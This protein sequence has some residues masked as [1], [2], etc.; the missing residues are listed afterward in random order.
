MTI[1]LVFKTYLELA[2]NAIECGNNRLAT[3]WFKTLIEEL[4]QVSNNT[5][6]QVS[7]L[8]RIACVYTDHKQYRLAESAH[9]RALALWSLLPSVYA[10]HKC[11]TLYRLAE[12]STLQEK[13]GQAEQYYRRAL[14]AEKTATNPDKKLLRDL[15]QRLLLV[16][17]KRQRLVEAQAVIAEITS[18]DL[19]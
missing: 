17:F 15:L 4:Q 12:L 5:P 18:L 8:N 6:L 1:D 3:K 13:Y 14:I 19:P 2:A 9:R 10:R 11:E 16:L 7:M